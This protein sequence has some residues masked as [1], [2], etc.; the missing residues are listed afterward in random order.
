MSN[1]DIKQSV[2][3]YAGYVTPY[4]T[5]GKLSLEEWQKFRE[6]QAKNPLKVKEYIY[7]L[8]GG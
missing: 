4:K 3:H 1:K 6:I 2:K 7:I 8:I 5:G